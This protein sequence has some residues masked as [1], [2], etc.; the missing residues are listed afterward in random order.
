MDI[1]GVGGDTILS[2]TL[3]FLPGFIYLS[4]LCVLLIENPSGENSW[5]GSTLAFSR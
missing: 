2:T 3:L 5:L 1:W 4:P